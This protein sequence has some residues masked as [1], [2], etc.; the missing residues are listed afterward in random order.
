MLPFSE[1]KSGK[2]IQWWPVYRWSADVRFYQWCP[3]YRWSADVRFYQLRHVAGVKTL[4]Y[5][6]K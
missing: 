1:Y 4:K 3:V 6:T 5:N 2:S